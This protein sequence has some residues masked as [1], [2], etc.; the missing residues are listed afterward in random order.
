MG[1]KLKKYAPGVNGVKTDPDDPDFIGPPTAKKMQADKDKATTDSALD[2]AVASTESYRAKAPA[3]AYTAGRDADMAKVRQ[4]QEKLNKYG[5]GL[6]VDGMWGDKTEA[7]SRDLYPQY[8][9][10]PAVSKSAGI[11]TANKVSATSS[12]VSATSK[13]ASP[14]YRSAAETSQAWNDYAEIPK[15]S[16]RTKTTGNKTIAATAT[17]STTNKVATPSS[18]FFDEGVKTDRKT[19]DKN[20]K[21]ADTNE[22]A[23]IDRKLAR[24]N[25]DVGVQE[26]ASGNPVPG[27]ALTASIMSDKANGSPS[28]SPGYRDQLE[29]QRRLLRPDEY[30]PFSKDKEA[31]SDPVR[32]TSKSAKPSKSLDGGDA[33]IY[34]AEAAGP[35]LARSIKGGGLGVNLVKGA[36]MVGPTVADFLKTSS[37]DNDSTATQYMGS[38]AK[39]IARGAALGTAG[40][41][42][43]KGVS[44][45]A[46]GY[47]TAASEFSNI[48]AARKEAQSGLVAAK[49]AKAAATSKSAK[50]NAKALIAKTSAA[51]NTADKMRVTTPSSIS[52]NMSQAFK[53]T[54][55]GKVVEAVKNNPVTRY[56]NSLK[57]YNEDNVNINKAS[58]ANRQA[59]AL[60][61]AEKDINKVRKL[62]GESYDEAVKENKKFDKTQRGIKTKAQKLKDEAYD[63]ATKAN[64]KY[65]RNQKADDDRYAKSD[66]QKLNEAQIEATKPKTVTQVRAEK[67]AKDAKAISERTGAKLGI[68]TKRKAELKAIADEQ[69]EK[70]ETA[71]GVK[72]EAT[73]Q[74]ELDKVNEQKY[75]Y[76]GGRNEPYEAAPASAESDRVAKRMNE[77]AE[78]GE[79]KIVAARVKGYKEKGIKTKEKNS[80][81]NEAV[82]ENK[83]FNKKADY[84]K[85][86]KKEQADI[87]DKKYNLGSK[88]SVS[89]RT[90]VTTY[91]EPKVIRTVKTEAK[92]KETPKLKPNGK[93]NSAQRRGRKGKGKP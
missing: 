90:K 41:T 5:A 31:A 13:T 70:A 71:R 49:A 66:S 25:E 74:E 68:K 2:A 52:S 93:P 33:A 43:A 80:V 48:N 59:D 73:R 4:H 10:K 6:K 85:A 15:T 12:P 86:N 14:K 56:R 50:T 22:V 35:A 89:A 51:V 11:K 26:M 57:T 67:D 65:D 47:S 84:T 91:N 30:E 75:G 81:Y 82:R 63:E 36:L 92:V 21:R 3:N 7:A 40:S 83:D 79:K 64:R 61:A 27:M 54:G 20:W 34:A 1:I 18:S 72:K 8:K 60:K 39:A 29:R 23:E 37:D 69:L 17:K 88:E 46:K 53:E 62:K 38:A 42:V 19:F 28:I 9:E 76:K 24:R 45:T 58:V 78:A 44:K 32:K 55:A 87:V 16:A 77:L